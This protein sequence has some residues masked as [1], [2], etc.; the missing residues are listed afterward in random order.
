MKRK[1]KG[2]S[3]PQWKRLFNPNFDKDYSEWYILSLSLHLFHNIN[4]PSVLK[5]L[6]Y[7]YSQFHSTEGK[8][9]RENPCDFY[10]HWNCNRA[11]HATPNP[12]EAQ[13]WHPCLGP[14][15][16]SFPGWRWMLHRTGMPR[17]SRHSVPPTLW[18][19]PGPASL[20]TITSKQS[21][22]HSHDSVSN[23]SPASCSCSKSSG[24]PIPRQGKQVIE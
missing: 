19:E 5:N 4:C 9:G 12:G 14:L 1:R 2:N 8:I 13:T 10:I 11:G 24:L 23:D 15:P 22:S 18:A 17:A 20:D 3:V 6:Y 7:K 21:W 16:S